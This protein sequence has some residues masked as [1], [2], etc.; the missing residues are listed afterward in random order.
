[1]PRQW[2]KENARRPK[3]KK[4]MIMKKREQEVEEVNGCIMTDAAGLRK[5]GKDG[6]NRMQALCRY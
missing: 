4:K 3:K 1:M 5:Q 2:L 6:S